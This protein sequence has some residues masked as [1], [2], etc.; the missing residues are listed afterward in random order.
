MDLQ[1]PKE[2]KAASVL[3][4]QD[5]S[6]W[7]FLRHHQTITTSSNPEDT[8]RNTKKQRE[9]VCDYEPN[10]ITTQGSAQLFLYELWSIEKM[11]LDG[12]IG[13]TAAVSEILLN[14]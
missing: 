12:K 13:Y 9:E 2:Y 7:V 14:N 8:Q 6:M 1:A 3:L 10:L 11:E 5:V 4:S